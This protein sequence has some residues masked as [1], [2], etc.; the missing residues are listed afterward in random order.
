MSVIRSKTRTTPFRLLT[1]F[2]YGKY[3]W[4]EYVS[5][6]VIRIL[7]GPAAR[8]L[9]VRSADF[10]VYLYW[11]EQTKLVESI[12]KEQKKGAAIIRLRPPVAFSDKE[13]A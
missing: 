8:T 11:L 10:W 9:R 5:P 7:T 3:E 4:I 6:G 2:L 13:D 1:Y 12:E